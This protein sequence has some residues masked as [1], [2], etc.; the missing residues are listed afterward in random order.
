MHVALA[1]EVSPWLVWQCSNAFCRAGLTGHSPCWRH[2]RRA[3]KPTKALF[4]LHPCAGLCNAAP[5]SQKGIPW[6][7][8]LLLQP[9][10][11]T[12]RFLFSFC[13]N[14]DARSRTLCDRPQRLVRQLLDGFEEI[15]R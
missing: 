10:S 6:T 14:H 7:L 5:L 2:F 15:M 9:R 4:T 1:D 8:H 3:L 11:V 12:E 13:D